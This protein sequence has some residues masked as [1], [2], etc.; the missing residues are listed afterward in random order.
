MPEEEQEEEQEEEEDEGKR[1]GT[2]A[3]VPR[4]IQDSSQSITIHAVPDG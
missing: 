3:T 4:P 2:E 1:G